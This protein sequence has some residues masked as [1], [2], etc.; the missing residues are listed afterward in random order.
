M[1]RHSKT[2][3]RAYGSDTWNQYE[4]AEDMPHERPLNNEELRKQNRYLKWALL[5]LAAGMIAQTL[6]LFFQ[7]SG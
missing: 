5:I 6:I 3:K 1:G 2:S 4:T 7:T